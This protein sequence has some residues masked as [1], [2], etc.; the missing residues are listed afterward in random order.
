M[1]LSIAL[2][3]ALLALNYA[4]GMSAA[5]GVLGPSR[6]AWFLVPAAGWLIL[7][8]GFLLWN[9][10]RRRGFAAITVTLLVMLAGIGLNLWF[11]KSLFDAV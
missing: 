10:V 11:L 8:L 5:R 9:V 6:I 4:F 1:P 3:V 2:V 7:G